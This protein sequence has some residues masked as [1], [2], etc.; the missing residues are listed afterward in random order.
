MD[1]ALDLEGTNSAIPETTSVFIVASFQFLGCATI[2]SVGGSPWKKWPTSNLMF[3]F[4]MC[5]VAL[6]TLVITLLPSDAVYSFLSLQRLPY[7]WNLALL[8]QGI[9]AFLAYFFVLG[10]VYYAKSKGWIAMLECRGPPKPHKH[11]RAVWAS[12]WEEGGASTAVGTAHP[13]KIT[14]HI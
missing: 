4:W 12:Q 2:F 8:G 3:C 11:F 6:S 14:I 13:E 10:G 9:F 1:P 5:V 7:S